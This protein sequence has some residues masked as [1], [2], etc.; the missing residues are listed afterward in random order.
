MMSLYNKIVIVTGASRGIGL[1]IT[2]K[3][4]I[5][6]ARVYGVARTEPQ[7]SQLPAGASMLLADIRDS[8]QVEQVVQTVL[9]DAR[10]ID[11]LVNNAGIEIVKPLIDTSDEEYDQVLDTNLKGS[12]IFTKAALPTMVQQRAG[13]L[14]FV[15]SISGIRGF[16]GDSVY[17][18]S[19]YGLTGLVDALD[20]ELRPKGIRVTGVHPGATATGLALNSWAPAN[21]PRRP[22]FLKPEDVAEAVIYAASQ[23][24]RVVIKQVIIQPMIEPP[25]SEFLSVD[26][27][28]EL[29][30]DR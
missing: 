18:A 14:I 8:A 6:G 20:E 3:M 25:H 23:P 10:R 26:L 16:A 21:D 12:F 24:A 4:A 13:H 2:Q 19:K 11:I 1:A 17:C 9:E 28:Q 29:L 15:N 22:F 27:V 7:Q 30:K 5:E